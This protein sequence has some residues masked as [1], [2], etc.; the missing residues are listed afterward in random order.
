VAGPFATDDASDGDIGFPC[1]IGDCDEMIRPCSPE[2]DQVTAVIGSGDPE[3]LFQLEP[4]IARYDR[5][6]LVQAQDIRPD[7]MYPEL[8]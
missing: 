4:F 7:A 3:V 2:S 6:N 8:G 1:R 5:V